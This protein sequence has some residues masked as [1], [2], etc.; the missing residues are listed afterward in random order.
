MGLSSRGMFILGAQN[1]VN[2]VKHRGQD[3]KIGIVSLTY[4]LGIG[5]I[6]IHIFYCTNALYIQVVDI[7]GIFSYAV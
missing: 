3:N 6:Q 4:L 1:E 5:E 2:K 7:Y